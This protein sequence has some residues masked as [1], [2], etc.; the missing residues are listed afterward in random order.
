M[1]IRILEDKFEVKREKFVF[2]VFFSFLGKMNMKCGKRA[3]Q[4]DWL[5]M[6]VLS[7]SN[8]WATLSYDCRIFIY[9]LIQI[10]MF[11]SFFSFSQALWIYIY[12]FD[13]R[14]KGKKT[15]HIM[16]MCRGRGRAHVITCDSNNLDSSFLSKKRDKSIMLC[17]FSLLYL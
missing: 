8:S 14:R 7:F 12:L 9:L 15:W 5:H 16:K 4:Y 11:L 3:I 17:Q 2:S 6:L 13:F 10:L 1:T